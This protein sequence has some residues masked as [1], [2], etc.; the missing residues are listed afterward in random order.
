MIITFPGRSDNHKKKIVLPVDVS[1]IIVWN[2]EAKKRRAEKVSIMS[3]VLFV[4]RAFF[5]TIDFHDR[6]RR[7]RDTCRRSLFYFY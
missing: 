1:Y 7:R 2:T 5:Q 3:G 6:R 4:A